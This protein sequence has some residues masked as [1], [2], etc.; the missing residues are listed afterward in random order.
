MAVDVR[1]VTK[2][3]MRLEEAEVGVVEQVLWAACADAEAGKVAIGVSEVEGRRRRG[4]RGEAGLR[5]R[6]ARPTHAIGSVAHVVVGH[7]AFHA[8]SR[9][10]SHDR[11]A[12][13]GIVVPFERELQIVRL[14]VGHVD[15]GD[16]LGRLRPHRAL[17]QH[18][19]LVDRVIPDQALRFALS[20]GEFDRGFAGVD[21]K[22]GMEILGADFERVGRPVGDAQ[23][24]A[25][26]PP[27]LVAVGDIAVFGRVVIGRHGRGVAAPFGERPVAAVVAAQHVDV[28]VGLFVAEGCDDPQPVVEIVAQ[29]GGAGGFPARNLAALAHF[30]VARQRQALL[31]VE[32]VARLEIDD[33]A[34]AARQQRGIGR[35][36]HFDPADQFG[37]HAF[38]AVV[39]IVI[40]FADLVDFEPADEELA[41]E[42]RDVLFEPAN[43]DL[44]TLAVLAVD[45]DAGQ[46]L[47]RFR[48]V[49]VGE[50]ADVLGGDRF[51]DQVRFALGLE[52]VFERGPEA[53]D[54]DDVPARIGGLLAGVGSVLRLRESRRRMRPQRQYR[55]GGQQRRPVTQNPAVHFSIPPKPHLVCGPL[56]SALTRHA[57]RLGVLA[58]IRDFTGCIFLST[59]SNKAHNK[60]PERVFRRVH[61]QPCQRLSD[62]PRA[63]AAWD[64][65]YAFEDD[66][67][68][69]RIGRAC[70]LRTSGGSRCGIRGGG[71]PGGKGPS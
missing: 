12:E 68:G 5:P 51:D 64:G 55:C 47:E 15:E 38:E 33:P 6:S 18:A 10:G 54:D 63:A 21:L 14:D 7:F 20:E 26:A 60:L 36:E 17:R 1:P 11:G 29:H 40:A 59:L 45:L 50:L 42:Q 48:H 31:Q 52:R 67:S 37:R 24:S 62:Q 46:A 35:L 16:R 25:P 70:T 69:G 28:V 19:V 2:C 34:Q 66:T 27:V 43:A 22:V 41:V 13:I 44:R 56:N 57:T 9:I 30:R 71:H 23:R 61:C 8:R 49:L 65:V 58:I 53:G 39:A 4:V 32:R 3:P